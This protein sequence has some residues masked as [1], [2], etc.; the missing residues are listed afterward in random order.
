MKKIGA[1]LTIKLKEISELKRDREGKL[2]LKD[3]LNELNQQL[4]GK[5][6]ENSSMSKHL[7]N[8][9][10]ERD[11]FDKKAIDL[12]HRHKTMEQELTASQF[13]NM[14]F[15]SP[16]KP[17]DITGSSS[18]N[19]YH[20]PT[21][22][23]PNPVLNGLG[24]NNLLK[25]NP[26]EFTFKPIKTP[27]ISTPNVIPH[28]DKPVPKPLPPVVDTPLYS[29]ENPPPDI[30]PEDLKMILS[31]GFTSP[32]KIFQLMRKYPGNIDRI[33]EDILKDKL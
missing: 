5:I 22:I 13:S 33:I 28:I 26:T 30:D 31:M 3:Q 18:S 25:V 8:L 32:T 10:I 16:Q 7:Y 4:N 29:L 27:P 21:G 6:E 23:P 9:T 20:L 2:R 12:E 15:G 17:I 19:P 1:Q 24:K 14:N 11:H